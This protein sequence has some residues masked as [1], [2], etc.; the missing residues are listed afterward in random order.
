MSLVEIIRTDEQTH[1]VQVQLFSF[2]RLPH[3]EILHS[4]IKIK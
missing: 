2:Y 3:L 1:W 4:E